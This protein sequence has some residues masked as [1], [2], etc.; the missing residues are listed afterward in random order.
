[1]GF[2]L[3][4]IVATV[5]S[6]GAILAAI[7]WQWASLVHVP[8]DIDNIVSVLQWVS[9][10]NSYGAMG[11][12]LAAVCGLIALWFGRAPAYWS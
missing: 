5:G 8:N 2:T 6:F 1:M 10:L 3:T 4:S 12:S 7:F 9:R 11:A